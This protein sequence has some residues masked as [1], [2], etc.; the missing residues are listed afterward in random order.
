MIQLLNTLAQLPDASDND[1]PNFCASCHILRLLGQLYQNLLEAYLDPRL[2][3]HEQL[4]R[5][6]T[7]AH[8]TLALYFRDKGN[9]IPIQLYFDVM[10]MIKNVYFCVAKAQTDDINGH[11]WI[12]LL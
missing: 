11:F 3:L 2:S 6:S 10:T 8:I 7:A 1:D 4:T 12:I 9:F 5:L